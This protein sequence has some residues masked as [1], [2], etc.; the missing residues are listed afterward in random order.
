MNMLELWKTFACMHR[1]GR[2]GKQEYQSCVFPLV[3]Q[4]CYGS[5]LVCVLYGTPL[6][7]GGAWLLNTPEIHT[8]THTHTHTHM[9]T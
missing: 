4:Q 8:H 1:D 6:P 5:L 9:L 7:Y 2:A 3:S